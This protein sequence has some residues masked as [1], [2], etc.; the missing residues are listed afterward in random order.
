MPYWTELARRLIYDSDWVRIHHLDFKLPD[1]KT[2]R[3]WHL[4]DY[5]CQAAGIVPIGDD[6]RIL[7][8]EQYRFTMN[9]TCWETPG[10]RIDPGESAA[11][12]AGRELREESG[13]TA[14]KFEFLGAY[15]PS[16]GSSNQ[17]F[18][19]FL[20]SGVKKVGELT[21]TN[22]VISL[23]WFTPIQVRD[24]IRQGEIVEGMTLTGLLWASA[25]LGGILNFDKE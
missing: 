24:M 8:V 21:D 5:P 19:I 10:G 23:R 2:V 16:G 25:R 14:E 6:G 22:E 12:A 3:N 7:M 9:R 11:A 18:N 4:I 20:A 1:G 15:Y 13:H 17:V